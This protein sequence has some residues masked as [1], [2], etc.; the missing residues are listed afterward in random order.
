MVV[1]YHVAVKEDVNDPCYVVVNALN[2][3]FSD[4]GEFGAFVLN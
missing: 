1:D 2:Y 4:D 3:V